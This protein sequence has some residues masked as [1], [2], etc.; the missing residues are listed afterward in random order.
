VEDSVICDANVAFALILSAPE[1]VSIIDVR[2]VWNAA[3]T[4]LAVADSET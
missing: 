4:S 1:A 2:Y 3:I